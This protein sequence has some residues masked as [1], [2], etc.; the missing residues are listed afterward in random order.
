MLPR[1]FV[2]DFSSAVPRSVIHDDPFRWAN[3]LVNHALNRRSQVPFLVSYR[4][5]DHVLDVAGN[6]SEV[7]EA[8]PCLKH[9]SPSRREK[10][11]VPLC[12]IASNSWL[13]ECASVQL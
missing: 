6:H 1:G 4:C 11:A 5:D 10:N 12:N 9:H 3:G 7:N 2:D 8:F 13:L